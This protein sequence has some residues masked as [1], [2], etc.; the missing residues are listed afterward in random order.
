VNALH[1]LSRAAEAIAAQGGELG[2]PLHLLAET[3]STNDEA[4]RAAKLGAPHGSTWL[5]ESQT[6]GRGRQGRAWF[7]PR[8]ENLLFSVLLRL[9]APATRLPLISLAAGLAV[10]E[11]AAKAGAG[12]DVR[13][14]WPN[15][16]VVLR[17][18]ADAPWRKLA[19]VLVETSMTGERV[20]AIVVGVGLNVHTRHFPEDIASLAT[21]IALEGG[22]PDRADVL[23]DILANLDRDVAPVLARGLG[24]IHARLSTRDALLGRRVK[25]E[26]GEGIGRGIDLEGR[27]V[28]ERDGV[29]ERW[30]SGDVH[31]IAPLP[32]SR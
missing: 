26:S 21:S 11:A 30:N 32:T 18:G 25:S 3:T 8:G 29:C 10:A 16:V 1:D 9:D 15:D 17:G 5:A 31:L 24:L 20:D 22:L 7:S 27:L 4:K 12:Q 2:R 6:A 14:K 19:G 13:I 28:V 23:A